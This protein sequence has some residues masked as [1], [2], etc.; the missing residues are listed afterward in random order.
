MTRV[1]GARGNDVHAR[2]RV[3]ILR[4]AA[5]L[6]CVLGSAAPSPST[7]AT[8]P[9]TPIVNVA[10]SRFVQGGLPEGPAQF[11]VASNEVITLVAPAV[12]FDGV[13]LS[14]APEGAVAPGALLTYT[15]VAENHSGI[16]LTG[17][18]LR[19]P[20][21]GDLG[22][23]VSFGGTPGASPSPVDSAYDSGARVVSWRFDSVPAGARVSVQAV[24]PVLAGVPADTLVE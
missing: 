16:P 1:T 9:N 20:L 10:V 5:G 24:V 6:L 21:D 7:A 8:L 11:Q 19:L 13:V 23:P 22:A 18:V 17:V 2:A 3:P 12:T 15:L 14:V 4:A